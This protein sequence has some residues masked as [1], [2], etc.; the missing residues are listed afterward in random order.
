[1]TTQGIF[2]K[3]RSI[4]MS[5]ETLTWLKD[6]YEDTCKRNGLPIEYSNEHKEVLDSCLK[7]YSNMSHS[8]QP[9][10]PISEDIA[11]GLQR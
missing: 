8:P 2:L 11:K 3:N 4:G 5:Y 1:L 7:T 6:L 10:E 9:A